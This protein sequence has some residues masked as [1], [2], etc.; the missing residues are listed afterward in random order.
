M[1][2]LCRFLGITIFMH[3]RDHP[4]AHFHASYG[5]YEITVV[6]DTG[7][8]EGQFPKR[9]LRLTLEWYELHVDD[10]RANWMRLQRREPLQSIAPLE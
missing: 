3:Y 1:P 9:A 5:E 8:V 10:L 6:L 2:I 7:I 4:P